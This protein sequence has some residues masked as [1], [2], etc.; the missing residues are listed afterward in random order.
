MAERKPYWA[1]LYNDFISQTELHKL[2]ARLGPLE[3]ALVKRSREL[4]DS[5]NSHNERPGIQIACKKLLEI[6]IRKLRFPATF[7]E[8]DG[9]EEQ[10][11]G[12]RQ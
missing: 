4:A 1:F 12:Q 9:K 11:A 6:K 5:P 7:T 3:V 10:L 2:E 8:Q